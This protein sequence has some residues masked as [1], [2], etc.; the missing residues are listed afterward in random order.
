MKVKSLILAAI[1]PFSALAL[2][3]SNGFS[4]DLTDVSNY[5]FKEIEPG[6]VRH[7]DKGK[8]IEI[9]YGYYGVKR[10]INDL[11]QELLKL[12][13]KKL[14]KYEYEYKYNK[15]LDE[16]ESYQL[17]L[18]YLN[19]NLSTKYGSVTSTNYS[20]N[21]ALT[22]TY[23][24]YPMMWG[25]GLK[26]ESQYPGLPG[27]FPPTSHPVDIQA[28]SIFYPG[29]SYQ[30]STVSEYTGSNIFGGTVSAFQGSGFTASGAQI[31]FKA[32]STLRDRYF[33]GLFGCYTQIT[34]EGFIE[35]SY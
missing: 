29:E 3:Q 20:C 22:Q 7:I 16:I 2:D 24:S 25:A 26:V 35:S 23:T 10:H 1:M 14:K 18:Q 6:L 15:I 32:T 9:S 33:M 17:N 28:F 12:N 31:P 30:K 13:S 4:I 8:T 5:N 27:P 21:V 34:V 19:E 11:E